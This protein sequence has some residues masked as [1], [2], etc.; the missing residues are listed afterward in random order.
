[1]AKESNDYK[2]ELKTLEMAKEKRNYFIL[3]SLL[4]DLI[5]KFRYEIFYEEVTK[6]TSD[7]VYERI[8]GYSELCL[9]SNLHSQLARQLHSNMA[10][11]H[12]LFKHK[13][14]CVDYWQKYWELEIKI[15][16]RKICL[17]ED[18]SETL[19]DYSLNMRWFEKLDQA[20]ETLNEVQAKFESQNMPRGQEYADLLHE[21]GKLLKSAKRFDEALKALKRS[22]KI[23]K[24]VSH[25]N[26]FE[27]TMVCEQIGMTQSELK[28]HDQALKTFLNLYENRTKHFKTDK[29]QMSMRL[30]LHFHIGQEYYFLK[31]YDKATE[32]LRKPLHDSDFTKACKDDAHNIV[33]KI[34][35]LIDDCY[36][37]RNRGNPEQRVFFDSED[38]E[39]M[40]EHSRLNK[41]GKT[42]M[43]LKKYQEAI[44]LFQKADLIRAKVYQG[45][46]DPSKIL[47]I[48]Y[49][50]VAKCYEKLH[51]WIKSLALYEK[52]L[53]EFENCQ[54]FV[55][56]ID[57]IT[58]SH[59][60]E[61]IANCYFYLGNYEDC[62]NYSRQGKQSTENV[63][64]LMK[65]EY[66]IGWSYF[67]LG[68]YRQ[69][70]MKFQQ[71]NYLTQIKTGDYLS[72]AQF[73]HISPS[74]LQMARCKF[75]QRKYDE[76]TKFI[77]K[78]WNIALR[79][80]EIK[81]PSL[82]AQLLRKL[83]KIEESLETIDK[84]FDKY[85]SD[86]IYERASEE[87]NPL[88]LNYVLCKGQA[89]QSY[90]RE[91]L[92]LEDIHE[93]PIVPYNHLVHEEDIY[94]FLN[95]V[96]RSS[97]LPCSSSKRY[98]SSVHICHFFR[99]KIGLHC[100]FKV[101]EKIN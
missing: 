73:E 87:L 31:D 41:E 19:G 23:M 24:K 98:I 17:T 53:H 62:I 96:K 88:M 8:S 57:K 59:I 3:A 15:I 75:A 83:N 32:M 50:N 1:M 76:A 47:F 68:R 7:L 11:V 38:F 82:E 25:P 16:S 56:K 27:I 45:K 69:A 2:N 63:V 80:D 13:E 55:H 66:N 14:K 65:H 60:L 79:R 33:E 97:I 10:A 93:T 44:E 84:T 51:E 71:V 4:I 78:S 34:Q 26:S 35:D 5:E 86:D 42:L 95:T 40:D 70:F 48:Y 81:I 101:T 28:Q 92:A 39:L 72:K 100:N 74:Y 29:G 37:T 6:S 20:L 12:G 18:F 99:K 30:H 91:L 89:Y 61:S 52:A 21:K 58:K 67:K 49:N 90:L 77:T 46:P 9:K 22:L 43:A 85:Y 64:G 94:D 54:D 36:K